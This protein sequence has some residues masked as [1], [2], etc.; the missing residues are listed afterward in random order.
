M[1]SRS[2]YLQKRPPGHSFVLVLAF[3]LC[4]LL[5]QSCGFYL[6]TDNLGTY[7]D[8]V[9]L[10]VVQAPQMRRELVIALDKND[11]EIIDGES[12][13]VLI[14]VIDHEYRKNTSLVV[15]RRGLVEFELTLHVG[16]RLEFQNSAEEVNLTLEQTG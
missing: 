8:S 11:V 12:Y 5:V 9:S 7:I 10:K 16:V 3:V 15:P 6:R 14:E 1:S 2:A 13:D 4:A